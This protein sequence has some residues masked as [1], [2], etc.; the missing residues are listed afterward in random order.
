M[1]WNRFVFD[2]HLKM[3]EAVQL[4]NIWKDFNNVSSFNIAIFQETV[5]DFYL[6][7]CHSFSL[8]S[9]FGRSFSGV[10]NCYHIGGSGG[11]IFGT[12]STQTF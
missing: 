7:T 1:K 5:T 10:S 12:N 2:V 9:I 3:E 8:S 6:V 4:Y 11:V